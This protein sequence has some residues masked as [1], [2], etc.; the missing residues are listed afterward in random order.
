MI[1]TKIYFLFLGI[2]LLTSC[3]HKKDN[4]EVLKQ[5]LNEYFEGIRT[6]DL[7]K[8]NSLTTNDFILFEDGKVWTNDS[9]VKPTPGVTSFKGKWTFDN[10]QVNV[11]KTSGDIIYYNH[12]DFILNDT[13]KI[14]KDWLESA[15]FRKVNGQ[16]KLKF[17]HSTVRK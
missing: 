8:L 2:I 5:I 6:E 9:L 7:N 14:K 1:T 4:P 11:D 10:M 16:W 17:L 13:I 12:G 15:A 3:Q